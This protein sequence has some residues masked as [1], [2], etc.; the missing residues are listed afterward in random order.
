[1]AIAYARF[2]RQ[3][4]RKS[5]VVGRYGGEEFAIIM[6]NTDSDNAYLVVQRLRE[7]F[8]NLSTEAENESFHVTFSAGVAAMPGR[9]NTRALLLAADRAFYRA[10]AQGRNRVV[11]D[12]PEETG[13]D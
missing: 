8:A 9:E 3:R 1:M 7:D 11:K 12:M 13:A 5:D 10:K 4:L 2:L 6:S